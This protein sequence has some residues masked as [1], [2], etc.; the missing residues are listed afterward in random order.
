MGREAAKQDGPGNPGPVRD[1]SLP[2]CYFL[3]RRIRLIRR[4]LLTRVA[5]LSSDFSPWALSGS[6]GVIFFS[7]T[8]ATSLSFVR[9][10]WAID[11]VRESPA[12]RNGSL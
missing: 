8:A 5:A 9:P 2:G 7:A 11:F 12:L 6:L 4:T 10:L 3:D 1:D